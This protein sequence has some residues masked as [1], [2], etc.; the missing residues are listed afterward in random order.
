MVKSPETV[1]EWLIF[2]CLFFERFI[3]TLFADG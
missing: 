2:Y 3:F 1:P